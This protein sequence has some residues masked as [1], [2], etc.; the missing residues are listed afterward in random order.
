MPAIEVDQISKTLKGQQLYHN[1]SATFEHG[2]ITAVTGPN[3]SGKSVLF[4]IICGFLKPD[5]GH[6]RID[7]RYLSA[8]G[9]YPEQFGIII[10]GP[11]YLPFARGYDNLQRL[12]RIR[13]IASSADIK[14]AMIAVGL[15]PQLP[16]RVRN[17]S[18]GMKQKLA[19]AQ[20][21]M[22]HQQVLLLD[23]PFNGLDRDSSSAIQDLLLNLRQQGR[24]I[25]F[26]SHIRADVDTLADKV[27]EVNNHQLDQLRPGPP[28]VG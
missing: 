26:T 11:G 9:T 16:Q 7:P 24:T 17:Y 22:E 3:G 19:I 10:D 27:Y 28:P 6:V 21:I 25:V 4:R 8:T 5:A 18:L 1:A 23:E 12:A 20:A 14:A 2:Q 15:D 13:G